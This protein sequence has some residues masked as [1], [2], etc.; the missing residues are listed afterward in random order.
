MAEKILPT[1][2]SGVV[3]GSGV[4]NGLKPAALSVVVV[5]VVV[6]RCV[7]VAAAVGRAL[8]LLLLEVGRLNEDGRISVLKFN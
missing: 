6:A 7:V 8:L 3:G 5:L 2:D 4:V 1:I